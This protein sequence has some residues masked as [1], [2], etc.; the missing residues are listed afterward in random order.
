MKRITKRKIRTMILK[1]H[2]LIYRQI[3]ALLLD[4]ICEA[5]EEG[6]K[7]DN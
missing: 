1:R 7:N 4:E 2:P 5:V 3:S 6:L